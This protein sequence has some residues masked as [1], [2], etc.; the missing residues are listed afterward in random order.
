MININLLENF[1]I[2]KPR[3]QKQKIFLCKKIEYNNDSK[4]LKIYTI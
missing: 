4:I 2:E 1:K 3:A